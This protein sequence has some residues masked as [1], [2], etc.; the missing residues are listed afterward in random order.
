[1]SI[2]KSLILGATTA[3]A[4][5]TPP[6]AFAQS[7]HASAHPPYAGQQLREIK[8]LSAQEQ[9]DWLEGKGLGLA[10]AAELNGY[11]GPMHVLENATALSLSAG[12]RDAT[13]Q[14]MAAHKTDVKALGKQLI[15]AEQALD[16]AFRRGAPSDAQ[17]SRLT[18]EVGTLQA[19]IRAAHLQTHLAQTAL[20]QPEQ[21]ALYQRLRGYAK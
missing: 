11:P 10:K 18:L 14:L 2:I 19:R 5:A 21:V 7:G 8:A 3:L 15:E 9:Q 12:Q 6:V 13:E 17:V 20:L 1:M 4:A 16:E